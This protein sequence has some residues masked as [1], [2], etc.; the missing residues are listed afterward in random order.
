MEVLILCIWDIKTK[1]Y[2]DLIFAVWYHFDHARCGPFGDLIDPFRSA[3]SAFLYEP[4]GCRDK[5]LPGLLTPVPGNYQRR[6]RSVEKS[7]FTQAEDQ[8][9]PEGSQG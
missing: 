9:E 3:G 6:M 5:V 1:Y 7:Q 4:S 8:W 2:T